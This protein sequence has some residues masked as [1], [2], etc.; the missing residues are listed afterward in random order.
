VLGG[1]YPVVAVTVKSPFVDP[2]NV[3]VISPEELKNS[4]GGIFVDEKD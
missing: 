2:S 1:W 3:P 4:P